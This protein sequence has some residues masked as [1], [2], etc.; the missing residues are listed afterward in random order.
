MSA[1]HTIVRLKHL[2]TL[3]LS[4]CAIIKIALFYLAE[5][6][7]AKEKPEGSETKDPT[8]DGNSGN[9]EQN[10]ESAKKRQNRPIGQ[11]LPDFVGDADEKKNYV[12]KLLDNCDKQ[13]QMYKVN[14]KDIVINFKSCTYTC[15][16]LGIKPQDKVER[17][18]E[19]FICDTKNM[20]C[21]KEGNCP[22]PPLPSC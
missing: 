14:E 21:P 12:I 18:P 17:I 9:E 4:L 8:S 11:E 5:S 1:V 15:Q 22:T 19:G 7:P 2:G 16:G 20:K 3:Q 6:S 13:N 10:D